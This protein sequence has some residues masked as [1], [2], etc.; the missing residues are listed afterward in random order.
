MKILFTLDYE[1]FLGNRTGTVQNSLIIPTNKLIS[2]GEKFGVKFTL[3]IDATYLY[4]LKKLGKQHL[5]LQ[6][7]YNVVSQHIKV[8]NDHGH[9]IQLHIH[10]HWYFSKY[11]GTEWM[12]DT[13]HYKLSDLTI[14]DARK[15]FRE[16]KETLEDIINKKV[17]A[18][19]AGGFSA[20]P[21]QLLTS[22]LQEN[23]ISIDSSVYTGSYY[24]SPSQKYDYRNA[25]QK[26]LYHFSEDICVDDQQ[27][28][29]TE[30]PLSTYKLS[31]VFYWKLLGT[32]LLKRSKH[33]TFGDG[34][35]TKTSNES[36]IERL[37]R[38]S[39]A[40]ATIDG[41][42]IAYLPKVLKKKRKQGY[43]LLTVIGHPKLATPYSIEMFACFCNKYLQKN[44]FIILRDL[45]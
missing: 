33:K 40:L 2:E 14:E 31:P 9:D 38:Y 35:A 16:S 24:N 15:I 37:T 36:I 6:N 34:V 19:R 43:D 41:Y 7:D 11:N 21:N 32:K 13:E 25:S 20:Q 5:N 42:K 30:I 22:L 23:D 12:L 45:I 28:K 4:M 1:V 39:Y 29:F 18:F 17:I 44:K 26:G 27:G 3:F 8:L 10:P